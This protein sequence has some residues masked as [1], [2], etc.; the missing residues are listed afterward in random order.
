[1]PPPCPALAPDRRMLRVHWCPGAGPRVYQRHCGRH[2]QPSRLPRGTRN[3]WYVG[4]GSRSHLPALQPH[5]GRASSTTR[6][7]CPTL[8]HTACGP[9]LD[10]LLPPSAAFG[11]VCALAVGFIWQALA[12]YYELNVS[13]THSII[14]AIMGFSLVYGGGDAVL[15]AVP[16]KASFPPYKGVV[17]VGAGCGAAE[18]PWYP[19]PLC[20]RIGVLMTM[21]RTRA[22]LAVTLY[23]HVRQ[24][25]SRS[26]AACSRLKLNDWHLRLGAC[27][28]S[29]RGSSRPS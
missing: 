9:V 28:L 19:T 7:P 1:M 22:K 3:L 12:S 4:S 13:A 18:G 11:M 21:A 20:S 14:G 2:C 17:P 16:D 10:P 26:V 6:I 27:R 24:M 29:C 23:G 25:Y 5:A 8:Q 15:W